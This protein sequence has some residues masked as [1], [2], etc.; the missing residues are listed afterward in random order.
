MDDAAS[1]A[2]GALLPGGAARCG[3]SRGGHRRRSPDDARRV[4]EDARRRREACIRAAVDANTCAFYLPHKNRCCR[5]AA[6]SDSQYCGAHQSPEND[7]HEQGTSNSNGQVAERQ[8]K[9]KRRRVPCPLDP[10]HTIYEDE[11]QKH[12]LVC[13]SNKHRQEAQPWYRQG[14]NRLGDASKGSGEHQVPTLDDVR[15]ML[16]NVEACFAADT[17][18][19]AAPTEV[20][21]PPEAGRILSTTSTSSQSEPT[22]ARMDA[23][24]L[25]IASH[26]RQAGML[27]PPGEMAERCYPCVEVGA[28][29]GYL[30][31][32]CYVLGSRALVLVERRA[33]RFKA[34]RF[35]G[36]QETE[37]ISL[38]R[39]RGDAADVDIGFVLKTQLPPSSQGERVAVCGKHLCGVATDHAL[40]AA[41]RL[42]E[43]EAP[44]SAVGVGVGRLSGVA[45]A[46][47]CHHACSYDEF[48]GVGYLREKIF[49]PTHMNSVVRECGLFEC[50]KRV[51]SWAVDGSSGQHG[52]APQ[53]PT[54]PIL[55]AKRVAEDEAEAEAECNVR[56]TAPSTIADVL[57]EVSRE[58]APA[59]RLEL[60]TMIKWVLDEARR[61][62]CEA[63]LGNGAHAN[64]V[65]YVSS[66]VSPEN[67]LLLV[68]Y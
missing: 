8:S 52:G 2:A 42:A 39:A 49:P 28:G 46:T 6:T 58:L 10:S 61:R 18:A 57:R 5:L 9:Q 50:L 62:W 19:S 67:R 48:V 53:P 34:E 56:V 45:I 7:K 44:K 13:P 1:G 30:A 38:V 68:K 29:R 47:C 15:V 23:Q 66:E 43:T 59:R 12:V 11:V 32:A 65:K 4:E 22:D 16:R 25:A 36:K 20:D 37:N 26:M 33:Y 51:S 35:M 41:S 17:S 27:P 63:T 3:K 55:P 21:V 24:R 64:V 54:P 31:H 14:I 40:V 60:G